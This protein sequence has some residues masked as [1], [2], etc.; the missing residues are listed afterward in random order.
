ML[1]AAA[2]SL[3][4]FRIYNLIF[5][6]Y[7]IFFSVFAEMDPVSLFGAN[8]FI[9]SDLL[10]TASVMFRRTSE[11]AK[12]FR[13]GY[14]YLIMGDCIVLVAYLNH[15]DVKSTFHPGVTV[16]DQGEIGMQRIG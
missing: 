14:V 4:A 6:F 2:V 13:P 8:G 16:N 11:N 1:V 12:W 9:N 15:S 3:V 5:A 7:G 10:I